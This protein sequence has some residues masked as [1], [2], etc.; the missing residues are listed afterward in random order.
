[1]ATPA[2]AKT[3]SPG[4]AY[5]VG[6]IV[7]GLIFIAGLVLLT[8]HSPID[9]LVAMVKAAFG[10]EDQFAR[11]LATLVPLTLCACGL[12]F[13]FN[14]GLYNLGVEGQMI[15][16][17][18]AATLAL[19]LLQDSAPGPVA[20][21]VAILA[22]IAGGVVWAL[23][24]GAL[25][26]FGRISE[27]FAGLGLNFV[28]QG[29]AVYLIFGPWKRPGVASMSGTAP[30]PETLWLPTIGKTEAS[31]VALIAGLVVLVFTVI[32]MRNTY[33]GLRL[34]A[35]GLNPRSST[36]QG[37]PATRY[38]LSAFALSGAMAGL[39]GGLQVL[40]IFHRLIPNISSN[41]GFLSL[42]I[43]MLGNFNALFVLPLAFFFSA[44]NVGSLTLPIQFQLESALAGVIQGVLV[45]AAL[46]GRG[47]SQ[48]A[49]AR[50]RAAAVR[51]G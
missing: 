34:R 43:V 33:F 1:M 3:P 24:A 10:T 48:Q 41:L 45:L 16:G 51:K 15:I 14:A 13:T 46:I 27:I 7:V 23:L 29:L 36:V 28:A 35:V 40:A 20:M 32:V 26:V 22:G 39:A 5:R 37:I 18:I 30:F 12:I 8:G 2:S 11:V 50:A 31:P 6:A 44:L 17:G 9:V 21:A 42:L 25:N 49:R 19:R 4:A 47:L 38:L